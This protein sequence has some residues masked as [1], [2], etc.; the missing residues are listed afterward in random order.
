MSQ[1]R[2]P[3]VETPGYGQDTPTGLDENKQGSIIVKNYFLL[4]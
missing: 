4:F 3:G 2:M 1:S